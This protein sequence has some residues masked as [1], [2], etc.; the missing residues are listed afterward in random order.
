VG[1]LDIA[2]SAVSV[3]A[4]ASSFV[5]LTAVYRDPISNRASVTYSAVTSV[6]VAVLQLP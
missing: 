2:D 1:G 5:P 6:T 4:G 3:A